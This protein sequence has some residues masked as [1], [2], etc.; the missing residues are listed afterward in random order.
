MITK[1]TNIN[2]DKLNEYEAD[3]LLNKKLTNTS[4]SN[5]YEIL[6]DCQNFD[7]IFNLVLDKIDNIDK[8]VYV[9]NMWGY[10]QSSTENSQ[11]SLNKNFKPQIIIPAEY[12][13]V[14]IIKSNVTSIFLK[15]DDNIQNIILTA[16]DLLIFKTD[17]FI[18]DESDTKDRVILIGSISKVENIIEPIK[19]SII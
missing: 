5:M 12:S 14:Y 6:F 2:C 13:F 17:D 9:K 11:I 15:K 7:N 3:I 1:L 18:K 8:D 16:G 19:K 4:P 10:V